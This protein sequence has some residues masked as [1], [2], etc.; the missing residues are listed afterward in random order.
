MQHPKHDFR[1]GDEFPIVRT[2]TLLQG[3]YHIYFA[4]RF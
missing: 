1:Y 2:G 4:L 3:V